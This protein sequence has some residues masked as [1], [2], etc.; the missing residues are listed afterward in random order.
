L[1]PGL[2]ILPDG[3]ITG[4]PQIAGTF[5]ITFTVTDSFSPARSE[6]KSLSLQI[7]QPGDANGDGLV[8]MGDVTKVERMILGLDPST[9]GADASGEMQIIWEL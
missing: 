8:N 4:R 6:S 9:A 1:P 5:N 3:A 7:Y 2:S